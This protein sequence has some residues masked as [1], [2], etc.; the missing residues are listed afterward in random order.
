MTKNQ[1]ELVWTLH[2][3]TEGEHI[4]GCTFFRQSEGPPRS[5]HVQ[6]LNH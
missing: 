2:D 5:F 4:S 3:S 6:Q 1:K